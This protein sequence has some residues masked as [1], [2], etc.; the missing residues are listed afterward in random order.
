MRR[1]LS[2]IISQRKRKCSSLSADKSLGISKRVLYLAYQAHSDLTRPM[3]SIARLANAAFG[4]LPGLTDFF[5]LRQVTAAWELIS[6]T[7]LRHARPAYGIDRVTVGKREVAVTEEPVVTLPFGTLL[8]FRKD[9]AVTQPR[10]LV[11]APLSGHFA[12]LLRGTIRT[13]LPDHD[14]FVT[15]WHNA[16]DVSLSAGR[17]GLDEQVEHVIRFIETV[18]A[19]A[20]VLAIC[21]P[22]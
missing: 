9:I 6:R 21:Q 3:R 11:V 18:G 15:D 12:T 19:G 14:V 17:F 20:H 13:L 16:R 7:G 1:A 2:T 22:C 4:P 8:H 5:A 10:V